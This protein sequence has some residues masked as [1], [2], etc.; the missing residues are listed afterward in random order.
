M[1]ARFLGRVTLSLRGGEGPRGLCVA[2]FKCC[3]LSLLFGTWL[4]RAPAQEPAPARDDTATLADGRTLAGQ[5]TGNTQPVFHVRPAGPD[6]PPDRIREIR[7]PVSSTPFLPGPPLR[8]VSLRGGDQVSC[9]VLGIEASAA[10]LAWFRGTERNVPLA[11]LASIAERPQHALWLSEGCE[12]DRTAWSTTR[13]PVALDDKAACSGER[14]LRLD[15][16]AQTVTCELP[17]TLE[18]G[19]LEIGFAEPAQR[20]PRWEWLLEFGFGDRK[21][22]VIP[23]WS[24]PHLAVRSPQGSLA[25]QPLKSRGGWR[26]L[27]LTLS[28]TQLQIEIDGAVLAQGDRPPKGLDAL[29]LVVRPIG[30][31]AKATNGALPG[32]VYLDD[33]KI[34]RALTPLVPRRRQP[35]QDILTLASGDEVY[36]KLERFTPSSIRMSGSFGVQTWGPGEFRSLELRGQRPPQA[37]ISGWR[38]RLWLRSSEPSDLYPTPEDALASRERLTGALVAVSDTALTLEHPW[39]GRVTVPLEYVDRLESLG[40]GTRWELDPLFH[41]LGNDPRRDFPVI[42]PE[43]PDL[44]VEFPWDAARP[45]PG[46]VWLCLDT[47]DLETFD[48]RHALALKSGHLATS[49][50]VND[51]LIEGTLNRHVRQSRERVRLALPAGILKSGAN[52]IVIHAKPAEKDPQELDDFGIEGVGL[53]VGERKD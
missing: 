50:L 31:G 19:Q 48:S 28:P 10:R 3:A 14:G 47:F 25:V 2:I 21:V 27:R 43:G 26:T 7:F 39:L 24:E 46:T 49:V 29:R 38:V 8:R 16:V 33:L 12:G 4:T 11:A 35:S 52:R 23:G 42:P 15:P 45:Q 9:E 32:P 6:I 22:E 44:T 53:E 18:Q 30:N 17:G 41:H 34:Y 51:Q 36:G 13:P 37:S 1:Y 40:Q 20:N 5:L